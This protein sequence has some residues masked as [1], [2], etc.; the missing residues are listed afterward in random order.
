M[1]GAS[2]IHGL[3]HDGSQTARRMPGMFIPAAC[4]D[5]LLPSVAASGVLG[6]A[7][8]WGKSLESVPPGTAV[9]VAVKLR[10]QAC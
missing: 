2:I 4:P 7:A 6:V 8:L 3:F 5:S 9:P 1:P 10:L